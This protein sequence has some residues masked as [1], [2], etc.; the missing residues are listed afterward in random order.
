MP[1]QNK[2]TSP[3]E[4]ITP[5]ILRYWKARQTDKKIVENLRNHY[6]TSHY[7]LRIMKFKE[8]RN[9]MGLLHTRKQN[10]SIES[11]HE[12]MVELRQAYPNAGAREMVIL[13]F[14]EKEMNVS[15]NLVISYCAA[16]EADLFLAAGVNDILAIDQHDKWLRF[17]LALHTGV[18]PF[19]S[20]I[21][22]IR[23]WHS[24][25]NP[26]L[27]LTYYLDTIE[28]QGHIP[29]VTQ[30]D[31]GTE[32]YGIANAHTMLHQMYD[33]ALQGTLQ[34]RWMRTKKNVKPE[35]TWSQLWC[36]FTPGFE[37]L[38]DEGVENGWYDSDNTLQHD[39]P[40]GLHS[41]RPDRNKVLPHGVPNLIYES[42]EDFGALDFK[43]TVKQD[44]IDHVHNIYVKPDHPVFYL[45]PKPLNDLIQDCYD[46]LG[47]PPVTHQSVWTIYLDLYHS[48]QHSAQ[49]PVI[50][51]S[52]TDA[53]NSDEEPLL[54]LESQKDLFFHGD[55]DSA[56][57]MGGIH[58]GHGLNASDH[59]RLD[60]LAE[61]DEPGADLLPTAPII[62]EE[63]LVI[64]GFSDEE[65][66]DE[67]YVW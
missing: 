2:P 19:S 57:Y 7:G 30:S 43:V 65:D 22:W 46:D 27:I 59:R 35:I 32:N 41:M 54:L 42:A 44:A 58:S 9:E 29:M 25:C 47:R 51:D 31:P 38:L 66:N 28:K 15:R 48:I 40:L 56:Y 20:H 52:L 39:L 18:E 4:E 12:A 60:E 34:H 37:T 64:T 62:E 13:L 49:I 55:T 24:N 6:D 3:L 36:R 1:N 50:V 16:Y 5:H 33:P 10:H 45:V 11:I 61:L 67:T 21:M 26:Q 17:G 53:T 14:H 23:V 8:I 63:G